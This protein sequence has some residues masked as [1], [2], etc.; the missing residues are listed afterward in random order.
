MIANTGT[1]VDS[2]FHR[3]ETGG[4]L[5]ALPL[6]RL[7]GAA[8]LLFDATGPG[9]AIGPEPFH[10]RDLAGH[11]V[12]VRT[13]WDRHWRTPEYGKDNPFLTAAAVE[14]LVSAGPALV[15]ID[16]VNID[17]MAD[18]ARPAHTGLLHAGIPI[19]EHLCNLSALPVSGFSFHAVPA[20]VRGMGT[21]PVRAYAVLEDEEAR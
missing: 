8:G 18:G 10:G 17:D 4:D 21:F 11:A 5:A 13:G 15:G 19:V 1:Y 9:R 2:P 12:L 7:A 3:F 14:R 20:P 6:E 16:S